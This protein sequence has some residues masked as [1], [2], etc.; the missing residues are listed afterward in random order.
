MIE[1]VK[2]IKSLCVDAD[3]IKDLQAL[4]FSQNGTRRF[5]LHDSSEASLHT[6]VIEVEAGAAYPP[7]FHLDGDEVIFILSGKMEVFIWDKG[8]TF[9]PSIIYLDSSL[10]ISPIILVSKEVIHLTKPITRCS[11]MEVKLGPFK[12]ENLQVIEKDSLVF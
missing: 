2:F 12:K 11:Y 3:T 10:D 7:H 6:M 1:S 8:S 4:P 9:S 5:C